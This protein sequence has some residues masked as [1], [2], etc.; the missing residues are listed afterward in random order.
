[1]ISS[2]YG[3]TARPG[4]QTDIMNN[5]AKIRNN[6]ETT[7]FSKGKD[8]IPR[9]LFTS[10]RL[11]GSFLSILTVV[12]IDIPLLQGFVRRAA[13][14]HRLD[15]LIFKVMLPCYRQSLWSGEV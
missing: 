13:V 7:K 10:R 3:G 5:A 4:C 2:R 11:T 6:P 12:G 14:I 15:D 1:M 9:N 8:E